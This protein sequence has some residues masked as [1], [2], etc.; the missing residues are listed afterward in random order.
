MINHSIPYVYLFVFVTLLSV[1]LFK[2]GHIL[3]KGKSIKHNF[4]PPAH[5]CVYYYCVSN[6]CEQAVAHM[7]TRRYDKS[8][9]N[10]VYI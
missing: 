7:R 4:T 2:I 5:R 8:Y 3:K 1:T 10:F 6:F 9:Q